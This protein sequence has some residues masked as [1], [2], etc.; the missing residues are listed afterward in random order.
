MVLAKPILYLDCCALNRPFDDLGQSRVEAEARAVQQIIV[1]VES[2]AVVLAQSP[3][4]VAEVMASVDQER[5]KAVLNL[6][7]FATA[8]LDPEISPE[9]TNFKWLRSAGIKPADALHILNAKAG[10]AY[11]V[12]TDDGII[13]KAARI[14]GKLGV[15]ILS[16]V[17]VLNE[18]K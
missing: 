18:V 6:L 17:R 11:F 12:T 3:T 8:E 7:S 10:G 9:D 1:L 14:Q 16:P 13:R 15:R 2:G 5:R 4:L